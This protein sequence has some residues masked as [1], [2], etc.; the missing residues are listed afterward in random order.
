[1]ALEDIVTSVERKA[2]RYQRRKAARDAKRNDRLMQY[3]DF[4]RII[5]A[6]NLYASFNKLKRGVSWK[7]SVQRYEANAMRNTA[8][9]RGKLIAGKASGQ[10]SR[11]LR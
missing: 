7:E 8:A 1:M 2:A 4:N 9:T 11:N 3:D 10:G 6:D 5:D